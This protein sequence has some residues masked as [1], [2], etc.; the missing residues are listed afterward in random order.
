MSTKR[1]KPS[2]VSPNP[3]AFSREADGS[4]PH[5]S[6]PRSK[7]TAENREANVS[8]TPALSR[9]RAAPRGL[10]D[11]RLKSYGL[12]GRSKRRDCSIWEPSA[13][14]AD[15]VSPALGRLV[16]VR[17]PTVGGMFDQSLIDDLIAHAVVVEEVR[18]GVRDGLLP[19]EIVRLS[20]DLRRA[21]ESLI[22]EEE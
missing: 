1:S 11:I 12:P 15:G 7:R 18:D 3:Q 21:I 13:V 16:P 2:V 10:P 22:E 8:A 14:A 5:T 20:I 9:T 4:N 19:D 17:T 6:G